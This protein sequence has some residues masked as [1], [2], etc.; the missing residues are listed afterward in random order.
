VICC[1]SIIKYYERNTFFLNSS[2]DSTITIFF[3]PFSAMPLLQLPEKISFLFS[4]FRQWQL[5]NLVFFFSSDREFGQ[6]NF[7]NSVAEIS[8]IFLSTTFP[9]SLSYFCWISQHCCRN[10]LSSSFH[11]LSWTVLITQINFEI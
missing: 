8:K 11:Q 6:R 4:L 2:L 1:E 7:G 3:F 9:L 10:S 5:R